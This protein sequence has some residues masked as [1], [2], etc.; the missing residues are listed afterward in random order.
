MTAVA[1]VNR[2]GRPPLP[3]L[4][5]GPLVEAVRRERKVRGTSLRRMLGRADMQGYTSAIAKGVV[6]AG[7]AARLCAAIGRH[8][9]DLYGDTYDAAIPGRRAPEAPRARPDDQHLPAGPLVT[10]IEARFRRVEDG[11]GAL[12]DPNMARGE[13]VRRVFC[14]DEVVERAFYRARQRGW[15]TL[16]AAELVCDHFGWHP[17]QIWGER[18]DAAAL[19]GLPADFD[20]WEGVAA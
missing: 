14:G 5:A 17:Y 1:E 18:Y 12:T 2:G 15:V 4:P 3:K 13:A 10:I 16:R 7:Q 20:V 19:V 6:T 9:R 11:L 8:P